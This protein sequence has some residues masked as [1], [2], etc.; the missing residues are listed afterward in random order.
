M[1]FFLLVGRTFIR[2]VGC[3]RAH[4]IVFGFG[5]HYFSGRLKGKSPSI[6]SDFA[7]HST[8]FFTFSLPLSHSA[9][10]S[11]AEIYSHRIFSCVKHKECMLSTY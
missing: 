8:L 7:G 2:V 10:A 9:A 5:V 6:T 4:V 11:R 1:A 3:S